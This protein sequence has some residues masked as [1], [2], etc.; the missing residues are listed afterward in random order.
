MNWYL[1][2]VQ[3]LQALTLTATPQHWPQNL[4]IFVVNDIIF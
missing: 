2:A 3:A 4:C 1:Y